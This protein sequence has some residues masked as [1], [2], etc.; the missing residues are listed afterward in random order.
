MHPLTNWQSYSVTFEA[1][2]VP[3][4]IGQRIGVWFQNITYPGLSWIGVDNARLDAHPSPYHLWELEYFGANN[5]DGAPGLD[6]DGD[7]LNNWA[8]CVAGTNPTNAASV[9]KLTGASLEPGGLRLAWS[10]AGAR[11]NVIQTAPELI[12]ARFVDVSGPVVFPQAGDATTN[13]LLTTP[14]ADA[15]PRFY[16]VRQEPRL[17]P[18]HA[19]RLARWRDWR[20][21]MF[22]HWG[23]VSLMGTEISWSRNGVQPNC[24]EITGQIPTATYDTLYT[25]FNPTNFNADQW[26]QIARDTGMKYMVLT[27]KHHDGFC[28]WP[29]EVHDYH[30]GNAPFQRDICGELAAAIH[31]AGLG[32]GWYYSAPDWHD[33]D[34]R[35]ANNAAYVTRM[36]GH[37]VELLGNYGTVDILW[38][39]ADGCSAPWDRATTYPLVKS[40]QPGMIINNRLDMGS[41]DDVH[42]QRIVPPADYY[43]PE[44]QVGAY[45]D[46]RP[47][48]SCITIG[49]QWAWKPNDTLK[50]AKQLV[51]TLANCAGGD[52]NL[53]LN[54]GPMPSGEIEPRQ[55]DL[56]R[57]LGHW[58]EVHGES[59]YGTRGGPFKPGYYGV[60]TRKANTIYVHIFDWIHDPIEL[61]DLAATV[62]SSRVLGG[63]TATVTQTNGFLRIS[64]P[65]G[66]RNFT[67]TVVA[68]ELDRAAS[69]I[70]ALEVPAPVSLTTGA[71]ATASNT[72]EG[73]TASWG[74]ARAVD[75]NAQTRWAT[76]AG[77]TSAWLRVDLGSP[78]TFE[79]AVISEAY[80]GRVQG[81][82]LQSSNNGTSW[83]TFHTGTTLGESWAQTFSPVTS[84]YV[85]LNITS[86]IEG[87]TLFEFHLY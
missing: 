62:V 38:F 37:L 69:E 15:L 83:Q 20:F 59:I 31:R 29:T 42:A 10:A 64:V 14:R 72:Y 55:V 75:G 22:I 41:M 46:Q 78:R 40:L 32:L 54:V 39:D 56:L 45:D 48:E 24:R 44:Q 66:D 65:P 25:Q 49:T 43:T 19:E 85:R 36:Q 28:L 77:T 8:E 34:C 16:R 52:G 58:L 2:S 35:T 12:D 18:P 13:V 73:D 7:G 5:P 57:E 81:F 33:P 1:N 76:D 86:A 60:S 53:L 63:G 61:P 30:I 87:P 3:A 6:P 21:G 70:A 74:P 84:R 71:P 17:A 51:Q 67:N 27:A 23:P 9:L 4:A 80:P 82:L 26:V 79:R 11:T 47:W 68:L 50:S